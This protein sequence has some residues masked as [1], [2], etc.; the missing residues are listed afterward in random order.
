[1]PYPPACAHKVLIWYEGNADPEVWDM[2]PGHRMW[3]Q[4][5]PDARVERIEV[6]DSPEY[7]AD[8]R[9]P[10]HQDTWIH[11]R[12]VISEEVAP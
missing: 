11:G 9:E 3:T 8:L 7:N 5:E 2:P 10:R 6:W 1:M 12:P 4:P